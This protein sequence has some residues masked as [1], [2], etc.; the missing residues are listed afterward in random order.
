MVR[1]RSGHDVDMFSLRITTLL[2]QAD[3]LGQEQVN[4]DPGARCV[5]SQAGS[6][7]RH[8]CWQGRGGN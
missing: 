6:L 7:W 3:L 8:V 5:L 2:G 4:M 1:A